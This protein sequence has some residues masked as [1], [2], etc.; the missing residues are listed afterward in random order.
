MTLY[1][2]I[3][4]KYTGIKWF[5]NLVKI[6][7]K[8]QYMITQE[9]K[10][11]IK[12]LDFW[13]K[14]WLDAVIDAFNI[15]ERTLYLWKSKLLTSWWNI[16]SLNPKYKIPINKR[17]RIWNNRI[18]DEIKRIRELRPNLWKDKI[19][20]EL[21]KFC[22]LNNLECPWIST[23]WR[24]IKDL[25]WLRKSS[26]KLSHFWKV[27]VINRKKVLRK[28]KDLKI[29]YTWQIVAF[30]TIEKFINWAKRYI[31]T[32]EDIYSRFSFALAVSGHSSKAAK[33][34]FDICKVIFPFKMYSIL[35]DNW[36]E[37]MKDFS[38][39]IKKLHLLHY[40][41][42]P[43][44]PKMNAHLER[45]N[46]TIQEEF[47]NY[48]MIELSRD[49]KLFN[50]KIIDYLLW[51]NEDRVHYAFKNKLSPLQFIMKQ[52]NNVIHC[53]NGWTYT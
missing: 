29:T 3:H 2:K 23:I 52:Y 15:W 46:R 18:I 27:K 20:P 43:R 39:E 25:W 6:S 13:N 21:E 36:S 19:H 40:H 22:I 53:K 44:T 28:P 47:I 16:E 48:H 14:Y 35:T 1:T 38:N 26:V 17:K 4:C 41:T 31:I 34:F 7:H 11:R 8:Y 45:F 30:D 9:A 5:V 50:S 49:I 42:Y 33:E 51:Y 10:R 37:F 24:L 12:I 32:F